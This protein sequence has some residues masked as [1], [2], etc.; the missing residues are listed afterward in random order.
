M[1][2]KRSEGE[3][4]RRS[5][6]FEDIL[7]GRR[8]SSDLRF[9]MRS[10]TPVLYKNLTPCPPSALKA[11]VL[12]SSELQYV[13]G[14]ISSE[15]GQ[16]LESLQQQATD[17]LDEMGHGLRMGAV[18]FFALTLSKIFKRLFQKVLVNEEGIRM[19]TET[20]REHP[21]V[22]IP[23]H[24]SYIDFLM[25]SY[26]LY[27][28]DLPIPVIA[29]GIAL[30]GMTF[31]GELLRMAGAFYIRRGIRGNK[32][33]WAVFAEYV[34]TLVRN[35]YAPVEFFIEGWRSRTGK[36]LNPKFGML[37]VIMEPFFKGEVSDTYIVPISITYERV[38]EESLLAYE[39]LGVP[40]PKESTL[41]MIKA[42]GI[43]NENFGTIHIYFGEPLSLRSLSS[44]KLDLSQYNL[45]PRHLPQEPS[46]DVRL[47]VCDV[48]YNVELTQITNMVLSPG[49]LVAT[50]LL[51]NLPEM[52]FNVLVEKII[53]LKDLVEAFGG[54]LEWPNNLSASRVVQSIIDLHSHTLSLI[55]G[56]V[57]LFEKH[58]GS[59]TEDVVFKQAVSILTCALYR[60][61]MINVCVRPALVVLACEMAQT[62]RKEDIVKSFNFLRDIFSKEFIFLPR[63]EEKDF[64]EGCIMLA[65]CEIIHVTPNEIELTDN[66]AIAVLFLSKMFQPFVEGYK[67]AIM[68]LSREFTD[69][70][71]E[72]EYVSGMRSFISQLIASGAS[73][74]FEALSSDMQKNTLSSFVQLGVLTKLKSANEVAFC[75]E[76]KLL[77]ETAEKLG[78][79]LCP[80]KLPSS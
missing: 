45:Q 46:E 36:M 3:L 80:E 66:G 53:W 9:A 49:V 56:H 4:R 64:D 60:N 18:R 34:K 62:S 22:L 14:Q 7:E 57:A 10:Y 39:L 40:K 8:Q 31:V 15:T 51:Q 11:K 33:Y 26:L 52:D 77:K 72:I 54:F 41:G 42:R 16:P 28:Y 78:L 24:Q 38:L 47:F 6:A 67:L 17:I 68:Y 69:A 25:L 30:T 71:T 63:S 59:L 20:I 19:L 43:L 50:I 58:T 73:Q 76:M 65:K 29:S 27:T 74:C 1:A 5:E 75:I 48:A 44:G 79:Q 35:G 2:G 21:V 12:Q 70:F 61:H 55:D 37:T 32:L 13:L 23:N